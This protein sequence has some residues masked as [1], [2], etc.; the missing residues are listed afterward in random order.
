MV[1]GHPGPSGQPVRYHVAKVF[2]VDK[3]HAQIHRLQEGVRIVM[4]MVSRDHSVTLF[5]QVK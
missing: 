1:V 3:E 2:S 5:V 4:E